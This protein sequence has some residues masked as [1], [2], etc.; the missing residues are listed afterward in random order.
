MTT[1]CEKITECLRAELAEYGG[2]LHLFE[3]TQRYLFERDPD[4]VLRVTHEI[5][6]LSRTVE[7]CRARRE[8]AVAAL[9]RLNGQPV[10]ATL[11]SM[12]PLIEAN[13]RPLIEALINEVNTMV[14]RL[15]RISRHNQVMLSRTVQIHQEALQQIRPHAF[16]RTY[17]PAGHVSVAAAFPSTLRAAG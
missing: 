6:E 13:V 17:S 2:L 7:A 3:E 9:A 4:N 5:E 16:T 15:R 10:T 14:H 8:D 12:L 1:H 11:R